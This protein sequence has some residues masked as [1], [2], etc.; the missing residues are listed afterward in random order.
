MIQQGFFFVSFSHFSLSFNFVKKKL[1]S[2]FQIVLISAQILINISESWPVGRYYTN[3]VSQPEETIAK[4]KTPSPVT[5]PDG[6][7]MYPPRTPKSAPLYSPSNE[8]TNKEHPILQRLQ[9]LGATK[10]QV[11]QVIKNMFEKSDEDKGFFSKL[12]DKF[13]N[14]F[15]QFISF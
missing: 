8:N 5:E 1:F 4:H 11:K 10:E 13:K 9:N 12:L 14:F 6:P 15:G 2:Y 7:F 3:F